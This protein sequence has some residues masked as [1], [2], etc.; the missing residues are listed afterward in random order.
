VESVVV[1]LRARD[2]AVTA[3]RTTHPRRSGIPAADAGWKLDHWTLNEFRQRHPKRLNDVFTQVLEAARKMGMGQ[4]GRVAID[5]TRIAANASPDK[6]SS[7]KDLRGERARLRQRIR[8][9]QKQCDQ[10]ETEPPPAAGLPMEW[11]QRLPAAVGGA[12]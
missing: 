11:K 3:D 5:S 10:D 6:S 4:L 7:R 2:H 1:R 12:E 8:R 9:W